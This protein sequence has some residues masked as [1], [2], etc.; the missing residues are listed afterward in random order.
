LPAKATTHIDEINI[1]SGLNNNAIAAAILNLEWQA[2]VA[3]STIF[4]I[5]NLPV[6]HSPSYLC[7]WQQTPL[8]RISLKD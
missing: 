3:A 4:T 6:F 1:S 8:P 5:S 2:V 7:T